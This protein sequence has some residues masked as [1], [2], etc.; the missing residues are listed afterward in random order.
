MAETETMRNSINFYA[1]IQW[2]WVMPDLCTE[3]RLD[4]LSMKPQAKALK[5][6]ATYKVFSSEVK[7]RSSIHD[8]YDDL[9]KASSFISVKHVL[10]SFQVTV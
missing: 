6:I 4:K 1:K 9:S 10:I 2:Y 3:N 5:L 7:A 8:V